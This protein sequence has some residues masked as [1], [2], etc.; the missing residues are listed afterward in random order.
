LV[1]ADYRGSRGSQ[2]SELADDFS[3]PIARDPV[4]M[5][6]ED[7]DRLDTWVGDAES[8]EAKGMVSTSRVILSYA[9]PD[10]RNCKEQQIWKKPMGLGLFPS[11][12]FLYFH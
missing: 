10:R 7:E 8:A 6:L 11:F 3:L 2:T 5:E 12:V 4:A 9:Y 1:P